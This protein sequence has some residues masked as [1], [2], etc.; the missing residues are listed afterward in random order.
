MST[1]NEVVN[2]ETGTGM[3]ADHFEEALQQEMEKVM[4]R[5]SPI[6]TYH[7]RDSKNSMR[8]DIA[9][10]L[11]VG[12]GTDTTKKSKFLTISEDHSEAIFFV[13]PSIFT[14]RYKKIATFAGKKV[15]KYFSDFPLDI[16]IGDKS[17]DIDFAE[18]L[19]TVYDARHLAKIVD[20]VL[21]LYVT[22]Y[23]WYEYIK[24]AKI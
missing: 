19:R 6:V 13:P 1:L 23:R 17:I 24:Q 14:R 5:Y 8:F 2:P 4:E 12:P 18:P 7:G 16:I 10:A 21:C 11:D 15:Y 9:T 20:F 22:I 3:A